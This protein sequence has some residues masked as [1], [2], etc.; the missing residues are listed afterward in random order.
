MGRAAQGSSQGRSEVN[1][2]T[3]PQQEVW[4]P[5]FDKVS[6]PRPID[7]HAPAVC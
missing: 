5:C 6:G 1:Q 3:N 2:G 4:I 7:R